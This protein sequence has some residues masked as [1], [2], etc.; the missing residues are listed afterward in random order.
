MAPMLP[1]GVMAGFDHKGRSTSAWTAKEKK[2]YGPPKDAPWIWEPAEMKCS[3]AWRA[4]SINT[5]RLIDFLEVEHR[6]HAGHENGNLIATYDQLV[7]FGLSRSEISSAIEEAEFIGL[8][9]SV[10]GGRWADTN[11]PSRYRITFYADK[12][13]NPA[14]NEWKGKTMEAIDAWKQD[15]SERKRVRNAYKKNLNRGATS[16]TTVVRLSELRDKKREGE[17]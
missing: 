15:R 7:A 13:G 17:R 3:P 5:R 12:N 14:T 8:I 6:N 10:R 11:Q 9:S 2:I 16:R 1:G 4:M